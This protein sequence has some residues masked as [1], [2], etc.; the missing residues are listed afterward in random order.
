[1]TLIEML[2]VISIVFLVGSII[3][4]SI[5][6]AR[7]SS[8]KLHCVNNMRQLGVGIQNFESSHGVYPGVFSGV[9]MDRPGNTLK[10]MSFSPSSKMAGL[11]DSISL[12]EQVQF[13][14]AFGSYDPDWRSLSLA[15][16]A[17]LRCPSDVLAIGS[18][19]S[20]RYC[21]GTHPTW[22]KDP[23]GAFATQAGYR[24]S[25][26]PDGLSVTAFA[27]ERLVSDPT[28]WGFDEARDLILLPAE[29]SSTVED[30][31]INWN[32]NPQSS[33]GNSFA[34]FSAGT[35][36]NSGR[37]LHASYYHTFPPNSS[38]KD[39]VSDVSL[40]HPAVLSPRSNHS[41][42]V[43]VLYGDGHCTFVKNEIDI[44]V[45]QALGTRQGGELIS[46]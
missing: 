19:N 17:V 25:Q 9:S 11:L 20:Y 15:S 10:L 34:G 14:Q 23:G 8:R 30:A 39:C 43:N 21:R 36:W 24:A 31:C 37:F 38:Y 5:M 2:V 13:E 26:I 18:N 6:A 45:W 3:L 1:M 33:F 16:P 7:E 44:R 35:S 27:S 32:M 12:A 28:R 22:P 42:G 41:G 46:Q 40:L 4:P 29:T